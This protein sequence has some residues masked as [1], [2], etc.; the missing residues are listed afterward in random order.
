MALPP[1]HPIADI[2][3]LM[4]D[5]ELVDLAADIQAHGQWLPIVFVDG[6]L[7]DGRNRWLACEAAGVEP[8]IENLETDDSDAL[9]WSLN[10]HRRHASLGVRQMAGAR[11]ATMRHGDN[12]HSPIGLSSQA[13]AARKVDVSLTS[14]KRA[15][16]VLDHGDPVLIAAVESGDVAVSLAAKAIRRQEQTGE[17]WSSVADI[18]RT[19]R[20]IWREEHSPPLEPMYETPMTPPEPKNHVGVDTFGVV[21]AVV[22]HADKHSAET[23]AAQTD[24]W[25]RLN[26]LDDLPPAIEYLTELQSALKMEAEQ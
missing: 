13:D 26:I 6:L 16:T 20:E 11:Y 15:K 5:E 7:L 9:A 17:V 3:P 24:K 1:V 2:W 23:A 18:K 4:N 12:Q 8:R 25:T 10:E 19:M 22:R 21:R 14:L